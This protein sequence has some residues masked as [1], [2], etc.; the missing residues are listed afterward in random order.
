MNNPL[1]SPG[2]ALHSLW[3]YCKPASIQ[4]ILGQSVVDVLAQLNQDFLQSDNLA[5]VAEKLVEPSEAIQ[6]PETRDKIIGLL[7][8]PKARELANRLGTDTGRSVYSRLKEAVQ[9]PECIPELFSFF[10]VGS[11]PRAPLY[12]EPATRIVKASYGLFDHQRS[13]AHKV[14]RKLSEEPR[15]VLLHMPTGSGKTRTAMHILASHLASTEPTIVVWLAHSQELLEQAATEFESSWCR[16]GNRDLTLVRY[17]GDRNVDPLAIE[18]GVIIAGLGKLHSLNRRDPNAM[19]RLGDRASL[20]VFDEAHQALAPTYESLLSA[21]YSKRPGNAVLGLTAT[22]GRTWAD[23]EEDQK[24]S[25]LFDR[26]KVTLEVEGYSDPVNFLIDAGFLARPIFKTLNSEAGLEMSSNDIGTLS[27]AVDVPQSVLERLG[28]DSRRNLKI[29]TTIEDLATR[30]SRIVVFTPS[31]G[32]SKL[33]AALLTFLGYV[34]DSVT[35]Q[36]GDVERERLIRRFR[37]DEATPMVLCNYGVLTTGF[38]APKISAAVIARP[39]KSLVL[40]SQMVGRATRGRNVGGNEQAEIVTVV[41]PHLPG[42]GSIADAFKNW[43][44][45]WNDSSPNY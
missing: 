41:D 45:V 44:D 9:G 20:T 38:D 3:Q 12:E 6:D 23:V 24:L 7:P 21:L 29:L 8:L 35:A 14:L 36:S 42:F 37:S 2:L 4:E 19:L 13:A 27:L 33:L 39:T 15:K 25:E 34:A 43:E 1:N 22:P 11:E 5:K 18:D 31:V 28:E 26:Q 30:H 17:W 16:I 40:Y 10:A 32:S